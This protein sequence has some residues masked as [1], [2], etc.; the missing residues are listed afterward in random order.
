M[1][2]ANRSQ[3]TGRVVAAVAVLSLSLA[4]LALAGCQ[5]TAPEPADQQPPVMREPQPQPD[6]GEQ[7]EVT[8]LQ[9]EEVVEGDG[10]EARAGDTVTVHY[11]GRIY[12][13]KQF[14]SSREIGEPITFPLGQGV[15]IPGWDEGLQGMRE[16]GQR[17]LVIPPDMAYGERG[18][19]PIPP[20]ATLEFDVELLEVQRP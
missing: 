5:P 8:E 20:N 19:G 18:V 7:G 13:G 6:A 3:M 15:V 9:I 2:S 17:K 10:E 12:N 1:H 11:V 4:S 16:G 14:E